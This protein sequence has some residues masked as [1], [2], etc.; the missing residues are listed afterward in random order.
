MDINP[1]D[2]PELFSEES[3]TALIYVVIPIL[4]IVTS[5]AVGLRFYTRAVVL[6]SVG[7]DDWLSLTSL[8]SFLALGSSG[9]VLAGK[10]LGRHIGTLPQPNG[11]RDYMK[12]FFALI[13]LYNAAIASFKFCFLAQYYRI[14]PSKK[15]RAII[16][17]ATGFVVAWTL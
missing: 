14:M 7:F 17:A 1:V 10:G 2:N 13:F 15:M 8:V 3:R 9:M 6:G 11:F 4:M 12:G 5:T 16:Y